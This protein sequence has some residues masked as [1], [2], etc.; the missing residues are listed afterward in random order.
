MREPFTEE[1]LVK[2]VATGCKVEDAMFKLGTSDDD[3]YRMVLRGAWE[4]NLERWNNMAPREDVLE[5]KAERFSRAFQCAYGTNDKYTRDY[6]RSFIKK[7]RKRLDE[8]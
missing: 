4:V 2:F 3:I 8:V 5:S 1:E 7:V 6:M